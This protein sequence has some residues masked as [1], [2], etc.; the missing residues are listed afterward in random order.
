[1]SNYNRTKHSDQCAEIRTVCIVEKSCNIRRIPLNTE[2]KPTGRNEPINS[3]AIS[4]KTDIPKGTVSKNIS[5]L[6][7]YHLI[8]KNNIPDNKKESVFQL[9]PAGMEL[10]VLHGKMHQRMEQKII[11]Y[12]KRYSI[13]DLEFLVQF[14]HDYVNG[15]WEE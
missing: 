4:Q 13:H 8:T 5:K 12:F 10:Y 11:G 2:I 7:S 9:T 6:L 15:A 1:N 14:L 3:T